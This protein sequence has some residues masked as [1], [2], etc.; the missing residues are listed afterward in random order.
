MR[1]MGRYCKA[2]PIQRFREFEGWENDTPILRKERKDTD[3][4]EVE[5]ERELSDS[6]HLY[7]QENFTVTDGIF[8]DENIVFDK[9]TPEWI[10]YCKNRLGFEIPADIRCH[11]E[12]VKVEG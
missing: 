9:T 8:L 10:D 12:N 2:Y 3:D 6:D 11:E 1:K 5:V 4:E 7:L